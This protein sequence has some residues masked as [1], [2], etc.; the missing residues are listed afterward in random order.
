MIYL[1]QKHQNKLSTLV[2]ILKKNHRVPRALFIKLQYFQ[3]NFKFLAPPLSPLSHHVQ[4]SLNIRRMS[5]GIDETI[6]QK[7]HRQKDLMVDAFRPLHNTLYYQLCIPFIAYH[8][9]YTS[10]IA[11]QALLKMIVVQK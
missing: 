1:N 6:Q 4:I 2:S 8:I 9:L 3:F 10:T 11:L 7:H 5:Q